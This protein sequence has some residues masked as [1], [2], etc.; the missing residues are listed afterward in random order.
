MLSG[1]LLDGMT[2]ELITTIPSPLRRVTKIAVLR[3]L[4][5]SCHG[6]TDDKIPTH[7]PFQANMHLVQVSATIYRL[8]RR[9]MVGWTS[10]VMI[11]GSNIRSEWHTSGEL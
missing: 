2:I 4:T 11:R 8:E 10:L 3:P 6:D 9:Q 1:F 5:S 7:I